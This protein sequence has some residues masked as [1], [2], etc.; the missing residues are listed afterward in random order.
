MLYFNYR[1]F[2]LLF[3]CFWFEPNYA[4]GDWKEVRN[5]QQ[6]KVYTRTVKGY[7]IKELKIIANFDASAQSFVALLLD[8]ASQPKYLF[9]CKHTELV[10]AK[11]KQ[12]QIY[13]QQVNMPW[14]LSDRDGYFQQISYS[15]Q[16]NKA[17]VFETKAVGHLYPIKSEYVRIPVLK[18]TWTIQATSAKSIIGEY[19]VVIDPGG[20]VPAWLINLFIDKAPFETVL[21]MRKLLATGKYN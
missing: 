13:Y 11:S 8:V 2:I 3:F 17:I 1:S 18:A 14:P 5:E 12:E 15:N 10:Q 16:V 7:D 20:E 19:Q 6:I 4:Q 21:N 9:A